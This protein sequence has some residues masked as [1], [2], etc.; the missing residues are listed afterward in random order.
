MIAADIIILNFEEI[1]RRS[2]KV[3]RNLP[4]TQLN[5]KPDKEGF[6]PGQNP[7]AKADPAVF[8]SR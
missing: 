8:N 7:H 2:L 1:R 5:W 3:W 4:G 6:P